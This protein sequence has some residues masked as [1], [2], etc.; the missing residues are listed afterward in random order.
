[1]K[2]NIRDVDGNEYNVE[3]VEETTAVDNEFDPDTGNTLSTDEIASLKKLANIA[4]KLCALIDAP[5]AEDE[6]EEEEAIEDDEE[7]IEEVIDTSIRA[8]DS[9][10]KAV[11]AIETSKSKANDAIEAD[12]VSEAWAKRYGGKK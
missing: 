9:I 6:E 7:Q 1:M 2:F 11:G 5:K 4:D 12:V 8:K 3:E 10:K